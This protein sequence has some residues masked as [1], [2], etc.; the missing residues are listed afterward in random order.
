MNPTDYKSQRELRGTQASVAALLG[1]NRVTIARRETGEQVITTEAWLALLALP[2]KRKKT[3]PIISK[4]LTRSFLMTQPVW[5]LFSRR[6]LRII[7]AEYVYSGT[8][9]EYFRLR[10]PG[11]KQRHLIISDSLIIS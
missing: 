7:L 4:I 5:I 1:V 11:E 9:K 10:Q 8:T 6:V 2:K 3:C